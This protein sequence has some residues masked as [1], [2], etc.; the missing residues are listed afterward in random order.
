MENQGALET[1]VYIKNSKGGDLQR[2]ADTS[3]YAT[4]IK[5]SKH[6]DFPSHPSSANNNKIEDLSFYLQQLKFTKFFKI[7][8]Y[9]TLDIPF[10]Y[11]PTEK[12]PFSLDLL[13]YFQNFLHSP[14]IKIFLRGECVDVP[15]YIEKSIYDFQICL[16]NHVY[17]EKLIFFNR[18][19][20]AMKIQM[21]APKETKNF[22]EFNPILGYIQGNSSFEIWAKMNTE[23]KILNYCQK[24][25]KDDILE[26]PFKV[27]N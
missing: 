13:V 14:P 10:T 7:K 26:V 24:F 19:P 5:G 8:E 16:I 15:I 27:Y 2:D 12:G 20:T 1:E 3:S 17:R 22:F 21:V 23:K 11:T 18:S 25:M 9:S 4:T 6:Q